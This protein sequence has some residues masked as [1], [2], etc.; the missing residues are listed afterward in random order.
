MFTHT[1]FGTTWLRNVKVNF[2]VLFTVMID[3]TLPLHL[4]LYL[5][6]EIY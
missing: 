1:E 4:F 3:K 5:N 2:G 6:K